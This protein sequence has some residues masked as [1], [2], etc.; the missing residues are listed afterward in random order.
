MRLR[1]LLLAL[2]VAS[3]L[4]GCSHPM[5]NK[6]LANPNRDSTGKAMKQAGGG[7]E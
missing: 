5:E 7:D 1:L 6:D 2:F 4:A 3:F